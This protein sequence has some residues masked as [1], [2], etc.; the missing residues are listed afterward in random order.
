MVDFLKNEAIA[1]IYTRYE[2]KIKDM[3]YR[4]FAANPDRLRHAFKGHVQIVALIRSGNTDQVFARVKNHN[5][6]SKYFEV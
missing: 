3:T 6:W 5:D 4:H 1:Q 2:G